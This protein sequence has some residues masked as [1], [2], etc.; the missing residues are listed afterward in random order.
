MVKT[1]REYR[2]HD[3]EIPAREDGV[4]PVCEAAMTF[5]VSPEAAD[6]AQ[7]C[8]AAACC[9]RAAISKEHFRDFPDASEKII[10]L[11]GGWLGRLAVIADIAYIS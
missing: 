1:R 11:F 3:F 5:T 4:A 6:L 2:R 10:Y 9:T 7:R 8:G